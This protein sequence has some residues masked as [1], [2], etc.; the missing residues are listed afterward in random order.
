M[1]CFLSFRPY[2]L[3]ALLFHWTHDWNTQGAA[4]PMNAAHRSNLFEMTWPVNGLASGSEEPGKTRYS[5]DR[6]TMN[7]SIE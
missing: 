3:D 6:V 7:V 2:Y 1:T 4:M 5:R